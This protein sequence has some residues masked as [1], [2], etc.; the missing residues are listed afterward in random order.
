M[1]QAL[2]GDIHLIR[3]ALRSVR[4]KL[5][6]LS[7]WELLFKIIQFA[8]L[9][10][11]MAWISARLVRLSGSAAVS[12]T[13]IIAFVTAP[14]GVTALVIVA[15]LTVA[16][17]FLELSGL[18][19]IVGGP[20]AS[21]RIPAVVVLRYLA[22]RARQILRL[23][24]IVVVTMIVTGLPFLGIAAVTRWTVLGAHDIN[25]YLTEKPREFWIAAAIVGVSALCLGIIWGV[26]YVR[27]LLAL[28]ICAI[29]GASALSTLRTSWALS[30][31]RFWKI[32]R[33][34]LIWVA[35]LAAVSAASF[36][37][38]NGFAAIALRL[39]GERL[40]LVILLVGALM[41][42][43]VLLTVLLSFIGITMHAALFHALYERAA[44]EAGEPVERRVL[45]YD[46]AGAF[47]PTLLTRKRTF[48]LAAVAFLILSAIGASRVLTSVTAEDRIAVT[49]HRGSSKTAPENSLSAIRL[50]IE[51][52]CDYA[53]I[54]VQ[55]TADGVVVLLHDAD[56]MRIAGVDK[57]IWEL[58]YDDVRKLDLGSSFSAL[59]AGE[60]IATL[61]EVIE[62]VRGKMKL[63]IELKFNGHDQRL[64]ERV[65]DILRKTGFESSCVISSLNHACLPE[66]RR[67]NPELKIGAIVAV[68]LGEIGDLDV[69]FLSVDKKH[70]RFRDVKA[71]H[72]RGRELCV[73]TVN[74]PADMTKFIEFGV[75][76]I[77][78]D[79]PATLI[80]MLHDR[81]QL[82]AVQ[83]LLLKFRSWLAG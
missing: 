10:P 21:A 62:T 1:K 75:D 83:R 38:L 72:R 14:V 66:L 19:V 39:S 78:T 40:D 6:A 31:G 60:P 30:H 17:S 32:A 13:D 80:Q 33:V 47:V 27:S 16:I 49:A 76:N 11:V 42:S 77:L 26:L 29:G 51:Q 74:D 52:G 37:L 45:E 53:E 69:D 65:V 34:L 68:S 73:W 82:S 71:L 63:N 25:F 79:D 35:V 28:P 50:A 46:T 48:A 55:E 36:A 59:F 20:E 5:P 3:G 57:K 7:A 22:G 64:V 4:A 81:Q 44:R 18:M 58:P 61:E 24:G 12:N 9:L 70:V 67:L 56:L 2:A 15:I 8:L 54:D 23:A 43:Y 41:A